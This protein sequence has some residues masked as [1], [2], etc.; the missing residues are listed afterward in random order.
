[1][2]VQTISGS[3]LLVSIDQSNDPANH[4]SVVILGGSTSCVLNVNQETIDITNKDS[5]G[6]KAFLGGASSWTLDVDAFYTDGTGAGE[7]ET[8]RPSTLF[9]AL[10]NGYRI[11]VKFYTATANQTDVKK[12]QGWGYITSISMN[13]AIGEWGTY[14]LSV[15]GD[16]RLTQSNT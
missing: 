11:A 14:S 1:M 10:D 16:G 8:V 2:A 12:Y 13:G 6:R 15:Q 7:G 5:G 4:N 9:D 3:D